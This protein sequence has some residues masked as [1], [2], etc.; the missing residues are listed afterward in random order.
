MA[1]S[2]SIQ[3]RVSHDTYEKLVELA[4]KVGHVGPSGNPIVART[5]AKMIRFFLDID[6]DPI[7]VK[8]CNDYGG[9][10]FVFANLAMTEFTKKL[11]RGNF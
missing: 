10:S 11:K 6:K 9:D 8:H 1:K 4:R 3:V 2:R 5:V 7:C